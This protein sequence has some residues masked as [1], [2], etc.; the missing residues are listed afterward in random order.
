MH[1]A[2][3]CSVELAELKRVLA[4]Q[5]AKLPESR[6]DD[7]D[8]ELMRF[9]IAAGILQVS[10]SLSNPLD[11]C[12]TNVCSHLRLCSRSKH[13]TLIL[14]VQSLPV[15]CLYKVPT[16]TCPMAWPARPLTMHRETAQVSCQPPY[17]T[18]HQSP[19]AVMAL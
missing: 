7:T 4:V 19:G 10:D 1:E 12:M 15:S 2:F 8:A 18:A 14:P 6:F 17:S 9:A 13:V 3:G 5:M 16:Y 11:S